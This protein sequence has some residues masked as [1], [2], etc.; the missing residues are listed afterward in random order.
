MNNQGHIYRIYKLLQFAIL[1]KYYIDF[2][3]KLFGLRLVKLSEFENN[4]SIISR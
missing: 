3:I 2:Y 1:K 4:R